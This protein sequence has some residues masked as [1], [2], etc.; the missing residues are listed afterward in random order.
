MEKVAL[1]TIRI[2]VIAERGN[3]APQGLEIVAVA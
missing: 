1:D 3:Q 2:E